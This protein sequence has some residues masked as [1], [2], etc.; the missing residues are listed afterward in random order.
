MNRTIT[1]RGNDP[2]KKRLGNQDTIRI[3]Q[4]CDL[5]V[6]LEVH[7]QEEEVTQMEER[8]RKI[9]ILDILRAAQ[10]VK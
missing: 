5:L 8:L 7:L 3:E 9:L 4:S 10:A 1:R 2:R 6:A